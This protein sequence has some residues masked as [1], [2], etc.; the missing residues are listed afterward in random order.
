MVQLKHPISNSLKLLS[1][2][3][4]TSY[5]RNKVVVFT[6]NI[7]TKNPTNSGDTG[8]NYKA[9]SKSE[10]ELWALKFPFSYPVK[11]QSLFFFFGASFFCQ[12]GFIQ[13]A[14]LNIS[15]KIHSAGMWRD[16]KTP[17]PAFISKQRRSV[18][19]KPFKHLS[20]LRRAKGTSGVGKERWGSGWATG[21]RASLGRISQKRKKKA[22][23][24]LQ[25]FPR[26]NSPLRDRR[27]KG[28]RRVPA[29]GRNSGGERAQTPAGLDGQSGRRG[30]GPRYQ[31]AFNFPLTP[32]PAIYNP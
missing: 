18:P 31:P 8:T 17:M 15:S 12:H 25:L 6:P 2:L 30:S 27:R 20:R 14:H 26:R 19:I 3:L 24:R 7:S 21:K 22:P 11:L 13:R 16:G 1:W 10:G 4:L 5:R 29:A 9:I 32:F 23:M 28:S